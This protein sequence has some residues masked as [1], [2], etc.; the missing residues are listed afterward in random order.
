VIKVSFYV[1]PKQNN[2]N[3]KVNKG[4]RGNTN[5][6]PPFKSNT[7]F[8][9]KFRFIVTTTS[10][11]ATSV[12]RKDMLTLLFMV[13]A[14]NSAY[15]IFSAVK[16]NRVEMWQVAGSGG[17]DYAANTMALYW[18]SNYAPASEISDTGNALNWAHIVSSPS[19]NSIASFW[20]LTGSNESEELFQ[21][22]APTGSII[23]IHVSVTLMDGQTAA[24]V[25]LTAAG[26]VGQLYGGYLDA[27]HGGGS[28]FAVPVSIQSI[29]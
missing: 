8:K 5:H 16:L 3:R 29:I 19:K 28:S 7:Q 26:A 13:N 4:G 12:T 2:R 10:L 20:S 9:H 11:A 1:M 18:S 15:R 14:A 17:N 27:H 24:Q 23:D 25:V 6:V 22:T 21:V